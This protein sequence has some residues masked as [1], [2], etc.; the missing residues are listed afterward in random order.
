MS[1]TQRYLFITIDVILA[2]AVVVAIVFLLY[3]RSDLKECEN[4]ESIFCPVYTC[5][6]RGSGGNPGG[7]PAVRAG[8]GRTESILP[9]INT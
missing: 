5:P 3:Y 1:E 7:K 2:I 4:E 6:D 9:G 8:P